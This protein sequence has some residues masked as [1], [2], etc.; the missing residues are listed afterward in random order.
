MSSDSA[1]KI[2]ASPATAKGTTALPAAALSPAAVAP[3]IGGN[4]NPTASVVPDATSLVPTS[5]DP[6]AVPDPA[7][8][9]DEEEAAKK[10]AGPGADGNLTVWQRLAKLPK[11]ALTLG[12]VALGAAL[13]GL[14]M[15]AFPAVIMLAGA[16]VAGYVIGK[17]GMY[18][19]KKAWQGIKAIGRGI[20]TVAKGLAKG[21]KLALWDG[22]K[23]LASK[24]VG[25][26][27]NKLRSKKSEDQKKLLPDEKKAATPTIGAASDIV[28]K[29]QDQQKE[30]EGPTTAKVEAP[31]KSFGEELRAEAAEIG[32]G[33]KTIGSVV[34]AIAKWPLDKAMELL[35]YS[36]KAF[37]STSKEIVTGKS[38]PAES[39]TN[40]SVSDNSPAQ[41]KQAT[42]QIAQQQA[43]QN[44][45]Q[46]GAPSTAL[47]DIPLVSVEPANTTPKI[48]QVPIPQAIISTAP[49]PVASAAQADNGAVP[50]AA[51]GATPTPNTTPSPPQQPALQPQTSAVPLV[52]DEGPVIPV[53]PP[54]QAATTVVTVPSAHKDTQAQQATAS[55]NAQIG[56]A[57]V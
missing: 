8:P 27:W 16:V 20:K 52:V 9:E 40:I 53:T 12:G 24:T 7:A 32:K 33:T 50:P 29:V 21:V 47:D 19:G 45:R 57:H 28:A 42:Q 34:W 26:L 51:A 18:L 2:P 15:T 43:Q 46:V 48:Q 41:H 56:R 30:Q 4:Q 35:R 22:P 49:T 36:G 37:A 6:A 3:S 13:V 44:A 54:G 55:A 39:P 25:K 1:P 5:Q 10:K 11:W 23:W 38:A 17:V 31:K 14:A